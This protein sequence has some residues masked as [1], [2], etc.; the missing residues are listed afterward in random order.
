M[1]IASKMVAACSFS[2]LS[3]L[4]CSSAWFIQNTFF[5]Y[6]FC[7]CYYYIMPTIVLAKWHSILPV[8]AVDWN[9]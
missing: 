3:T 4:I 6:L 2:P 7:I 9:F 5:L 8:A 1:P